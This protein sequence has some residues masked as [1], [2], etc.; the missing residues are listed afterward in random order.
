MKKSILIILIL[1]T[2]TF[3]TRAQ[4]QPQ[5]IDNSEKKALVETVV[6]ILQKQ[7]VFPEVAKKMTDLIRKNLKAGKYMAVDDPR[8]FAGKLTEDLR[9]ISRDR[10]LGVRYAPE[11]IREMKTTDDAKKK[12][13]QEFQKKLDRIDNYGFKEIKILSGNVGCLKFNYF[14]AAQEAFQVAVGAMAFLANCDALIID[15]RENG[16]GNPEM[17]QLLSSYFFAGEPRHLNSFYYRLDEKTEQYW[18]LPFV[19]GSKLAET[20]LYV[21]T[22]DYTFSGAE[23]FTYNLK[24][25]KRATIVGETTG[26]GAHPVKMEILNDHFVVGVPYARA[27]N[28]ISKTNWEGT[29]IEPDVKV[30][31][32]QALKKAHFMAL[33]KLAAREKDE[34]IKITYQWALD[35]L[36][37]EMNPVTV[38]EELLKSYSGNYGPRKIVFEN[39]S[40]YYLR[41]NGPRMKMIPMSEDYFRFEEVAYFRLKIFRKDGQVTGLEGHYDNGTIDANSRTN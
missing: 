14:S 10:H 1:L 30:P 13:D 5:P 23:E 24:N 32:D 8:A 2:C 17:I 19:P 25:M 22:S 37:A 4:S 9:S 12:A 7:Y 39:N 3:I 35:G 29:G 26:G 18:T 33:E 6:S 11:R 28:P 40:L 31:A 38:M 27:V 34:R 41:E 16:G 21:L 20:D 36:K 15:L